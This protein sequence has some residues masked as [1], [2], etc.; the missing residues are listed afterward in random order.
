MVERSRERE[1]ERERRRTCRPSNLEIGLLRETTEPTKPFISTL[2]V[3]MMEIRAHTTRCTHSVHTPPRAAAAAVNFGA[4]REGATESPDPLP[5]CDAG[6]GG[7]DPVDPVQ[8][9]A[10]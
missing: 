9:G 6:A 4:N 3:N 1:R 8:Q 10:R 7:G 2:A 5:R